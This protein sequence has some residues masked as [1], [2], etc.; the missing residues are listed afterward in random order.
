MQPVVSGARASI[1]KRIAVFVFLLIATTIVVAQWVGQ[2]LQSPQTGWDFPVFYI[3]GRLPLTLLYDRAAFAVFWQQHLFPLGVPHWAPY[4]RPSIFSFLLRPISGLPYFH[5]LWLWL[6][7][8]LTAYLASVGLI[9]QR[10]HLPGFFLPACT[11][12]FPALAG[13]ISGADASFLFLVVVLALFLLEREHDTLAAVALTACL[14]KFNLVLL[15]PF[16]LLLHRRYRALVCFAIGGV[17]IAGVSAALTPAREYVTAVID[18][19]RKT[20]GFFPVGLRGFSV[21]IGQSWCY[22]ILAAGIFVLCC[23]LMKRL[24]LIDAFCVA[25]TGALLISPYITWYDSTLLVLPIA[26]VFARSGPA[27][28]VACLAV[29]VAVPLWEHGGGNNGPI[30]FMHVGVEALLLAYFVKATGARLR[31]HNFERFKRMA[32]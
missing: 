5:A 4:V 7:A 6:A 13:I 17:F 23:W 8:G 15:V 1:Q 32:A 30:G 10:F 24:L 25:I 27:V 28:R 21:A 22:P 16:L 26:V 18:A 19:Q 20:T 11:A 9:I 31:M 12:F 14:C 29:L 3:A 2:A